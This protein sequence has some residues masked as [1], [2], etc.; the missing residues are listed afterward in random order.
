MSYK[1]VDASTTRPYQDRT[2]M[3]ANVPHVDEL[4][5]TSAPLKSAAF[6]IGDYCREY[7]GEG[8]SRKGYIL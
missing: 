3:P 7:N 2:P 1:D 8:Y 6:F 4:G 5:V